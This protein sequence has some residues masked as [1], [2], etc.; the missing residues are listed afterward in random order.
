MCDELELTPEEQEELE[1]KCCE[2]EEAHPNV[3]VRSR[4]LHPYFEELLMAVVRVRLAEFF[5]LFN[6]NWKPDNPEL[7]KDLVKSRP[8][9]EE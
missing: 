1:R 4:L 2:W 5:P 3:D 8:I 9:L 6:G 7:M